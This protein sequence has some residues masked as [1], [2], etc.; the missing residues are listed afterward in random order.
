MFT[1]E[2]CGTLIAGDDEAAEAAAD[3]AAAGQAEESAAQSERLPGATLAVGR[4]GCD[5][6]SAGSR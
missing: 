4:P 2:G 5:A 3:A 1:R 6:P